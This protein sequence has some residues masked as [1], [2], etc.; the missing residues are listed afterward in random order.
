MVASKLMN[1]CYW[2][3]LFV[4][5]NLLMVLGIIVGAVVFG[6]FPSIHAASKVSK[7]WLEKSTTSI[8]KTFWS[9]YRQN[10]WIAE[11]Y[12][13]VALFLMVVA[14]SNI[15][16]WGNMDVTFSVVLKYAWYFM[17]FFL[18]IGSFLIHPL[19]IDERMNWKETVKLFIFSLSQP[20]IYV[21]VFV[22]LLVIYLAI[23]LVPGIM[24]FFV[25]S[26]SVF[27]CM[28][29]TQL[30]KRKIL[31]LQKKWGNRES[32]SSDKPSEQW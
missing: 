19:I 6:I 25:G 1:A 3:M 21:L 4:Y 31:K 8:W 12:G 14:F 23:L 16:F 11:K 13:Y 2:V 10:F 27:W 18:S 30:F 29:N 5:L 20:H 15:M 7:V 32:V 22:G 17:F 24:L 9:S 28:F 26:L